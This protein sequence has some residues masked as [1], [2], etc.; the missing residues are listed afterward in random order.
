M[1]ET[2]QLRLYSSTIADILMSIIEVYGLLDTAMAKA[3]C[4]S[5]LVRLLKM[6]ALVAEGVRRLFLPET[7]PWQ[8]QFSGVL[9]NL[10]GAVHA[11]TLDSPPYTLSGSTYSR[12]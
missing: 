9:S 3:Q 1:M 6:A 12:D 5:I 10:R 7:Y 2:K 11:T 8:Q 4:G